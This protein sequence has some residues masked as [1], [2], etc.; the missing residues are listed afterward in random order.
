MSAYILSL[1]VAGATP[2]SELIVSRVR[3]LCS[4]A[5]GSDFELSVIDVTER[6]DLAEEHRILATP[7]LVREQPA[8]RRYI[9]GDLS[10]IEKV[11]QALEMSLASLSDTQEPTQTTEEEQ[12]YDGE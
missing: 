6:P 12:H 1:Y 10:H 5:F 4:Q 2:K 3:A 8:P 11:V 9:I 7:T